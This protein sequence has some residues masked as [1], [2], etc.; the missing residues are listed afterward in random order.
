[1]DI[2]T[3]PVNGM[4][5]SI[6]RVINGVIVDRYALDDKRL[7]R[8]WRLDHTTELLP[9]PNT[10]FLA[11]AN[12]AGVLFAADWWTK[13]YFQNG[14]VKPT[15]IAVKGMVIGDKKD[16]LQSS[17]AKFM[18]GIAKGWSELAKVINAETMDVK[19]I[20]DG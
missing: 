6:D 4:V 16:E 11:L 12:S 8:M 19:T 15:L 5:R 2:V 14:A 7:L 17:F 18:R 20:G 3:D 1:M 10:E 13:K 9:S